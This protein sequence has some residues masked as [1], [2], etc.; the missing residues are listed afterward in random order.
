VP[1]IVVSPWSRGGYVCSQIFDHTSVIRFLEKWTG[2]Q[3]PNI[4]AWRRKVCGDLTSAFDFT[5]PNTNFPSLPNLSPIVCTNGIGILPAGPQAMPAQE[6]GTNLIRPRPYGPNAFAI[7]DCS[8]AQ[9]GITMTNAGSASTHFMIFANA[10]RTDG[11]WQYD[12]DPHTSLTAYFNVAQSQG[13]YDL[14]CYGPH[15][16]HRR[17]VDNININ[18]NQLDVTASVDTDAFAVKLALRNSGPVPVVFS[19]TNLYQTA[20][21]HTYIVQPGDTATAT[22]STTNDNGQGY[23]LAAAVSGNATFLRTFTGDS[24][25]I[26]PPVGTNGPPILTNSLPTVTNLSARVAGPNL[27]VSFPSS[28]SACTLEFSTNLAPFLWQG[29]TQ[30][31]TPFGSNICVTVPITANRMFFRLRP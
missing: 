4:S 1:A 5:N 30:P 19:I 8:A 21:A 6:A 16:F 27:V 25:P 18:C 9:V 23:S 26:A 31:R 12:V 28:A 3:E 29:V 7:T 20:A 13:A 22:F 2:V 15:R 17:F 11:P 14:T 24:D 10:Y